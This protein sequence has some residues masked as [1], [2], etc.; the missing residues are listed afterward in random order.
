MTA[1]TTDANGLNDERS[2]AII[3]RAKGWFE[4][5]Q[6]EHDKNY[7]FPPLYHRLSEFCAQFNKTAAGKAAIAAATGTP[8]AMNPSS[9]SKSPPTAPKGPANKKV[10]GPLFA[11]LHQFT[12]WQPRKGK[13][14]PNTAVD[15]PADIDEDSVI[16]INR[17]PSFP[18]RHFSPRRVSPFARCLL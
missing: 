9:K 15:N 17:C 18:L 8:Q 3:E 14:S 2:L 10:S 16:I 4:K 5:W 7:V 13:G 12:L 1:L 6:A 11:I